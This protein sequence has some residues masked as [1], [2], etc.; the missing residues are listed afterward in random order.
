MSDMLKRAN[1]TPVSPNLLGA[2]ME[3]H[4]DM[5]P[6]DRASFE[7]R[8]VRMFGLLED[9]GISGRRMADLSVA[10]EFRMTAL[11]QLVKGDGARGWTMAGNEEGLTFLHADVLKVAAKE[12]LIENTER[13][14]AFDADS[15]TRHLLRV[16]EARGRA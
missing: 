14:P 4:A 1:R 15:F 10:I 3:M 12:P 5:P 9:R 8:A 7:G 11:A 2:V 13:Q 16:S 6:E